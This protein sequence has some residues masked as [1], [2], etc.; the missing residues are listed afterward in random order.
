MS[1]NN[2][3]KIVLADGAPRPIP[4]ACEELGDICKSHLYNLM[5]DSKVRSIQIG[6]RTFIPHSEIKRIQEEGT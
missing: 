5:N 1:S 4:T 6:G 2:K 3:E